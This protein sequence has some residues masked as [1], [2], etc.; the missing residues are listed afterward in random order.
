MR[1]KEHARFHYSH[2]VV[3]HRDRSRPVAVAKEAVGVA[4]AAVVVAYEAVGVV[5]RQWA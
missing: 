5:K 4:K 1:P 3:K 2:S